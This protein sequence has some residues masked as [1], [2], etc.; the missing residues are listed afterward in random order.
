VPELLSANSVTSA[1]PSHPPFEPA[2]HSLTLCFCPTH[3]HLSHSGFSLRAEPG[4]RQ[5]DTSD[6][7]VRQLMDELPSPALWKDLG[8]LL[9]EPLKRPLPV[10]G[11]LYDSLRHIVGPNLLMPLHQASDNFA[12]SANACSPA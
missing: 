2:L 10:L 8:R 1:L 7:Y 5:R 9:R 4:S 11:Y 3:L 12:F 6:E